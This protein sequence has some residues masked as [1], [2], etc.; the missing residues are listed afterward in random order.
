[1]DLHGAVGYAAA[2]LRREQFGAR[3]LGSHV[4]PLVAAARGID[5]HRSRSVD[6]GPAVGQHGL[7]QLE[8]G[9][10]LTELLAF[11]RIGERIGQHPFRGGDAHSRDVQPSLVEHFHRRVEPDAF[12][13]A[14]QVGRGHAAVV[15]YDVAGVR[16][17]LPHFLVDLAQ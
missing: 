14:D 11:H 1:M 2:H 6:L 7:H 8:F 10:R 15:E 3:G 13:A 12:A 9:D 16:A 4:A 5:D 17:P